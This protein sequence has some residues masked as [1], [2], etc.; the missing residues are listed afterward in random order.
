MATVSGWEPNLE[1][2]GNR[3][4]SSAPVW[5][6]KHFLGGFRVYGLGFRAQG[7]A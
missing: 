2:A 1:Y 5:T 6:K 3:L 7:L 4:K